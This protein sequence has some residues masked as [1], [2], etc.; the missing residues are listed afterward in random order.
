MHNEMNLSTTAEDM[1]AAASEHAECEAALAA[2][3]SARGSDAI[4]REDAAEAMA[5]ARGNDG[6]GGDTFLEYM[7]VSDYERRMSAA[8]E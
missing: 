5:E 1:H 2:M 6:V 7:S 4:A 3:E 8:N